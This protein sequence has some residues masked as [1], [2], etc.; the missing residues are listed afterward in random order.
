MGETALMRWAAGEGQSEE[1]GS[2]GEWVEA[3]VER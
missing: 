3:E 2:Y 1:R